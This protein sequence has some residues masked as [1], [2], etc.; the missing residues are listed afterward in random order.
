MDSEG[1]NNL[2]YGLK[3]DGTSVAVNPIRDSIFKSNL[4]LYYK[5]GNASTIMSTM[6]T[7]I[8]KK[9]FP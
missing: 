4:E 9:V 8:V 2:F 5:I 3:G 7:P 1:G 6:G